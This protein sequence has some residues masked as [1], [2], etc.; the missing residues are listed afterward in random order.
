MRQ[1]ACL[2]LQH[3]VATACSAVEADTTSFQGNIVMP[4]DVFLVTCISSK[5][6]QKAAMLICMLQVAYAAET[7]WLLLAFAALPLMFPCCH[8]AACAD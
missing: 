1:Y 2:L 6:L 4:K 8:P 3:Y 5:V 7:P